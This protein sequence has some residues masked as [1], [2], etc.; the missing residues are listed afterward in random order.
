MEPS[1][2]QVASLLN[3]ELP[4]KN[5]GTEVETRPIR[6]HDRIPSP[7]GHK[8]ISPRSP[9]TRKAMHQFDSGRRSDSDRA[10]ASGAQLGMEATTCRALRRDTFPPPNSLEPKVWR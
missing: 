6:G 1:L 2:K 10:R 8:P 7:P 3:L 4:G 5:T 9:K